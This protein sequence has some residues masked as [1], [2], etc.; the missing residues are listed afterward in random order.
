[1]HF[2]KTQRFFNELLFLFQQLILLE[3]KLQA[4]SVLKVPTFLICWCGLNVEL[5]GFL[6]V[7]SPQIE[8]SGRVKISNISLKFCKLS[9]V[10]KPILSNLVDNLFHFFLP[11]FFGFLSHGFQSLFDFTAVSEADSNFQGLI[12]CPNR[13]AQFECLVV[14]GRSQ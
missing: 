5:V 9:F 4:H 1:M 14:L 3:R 11:P 13:K 7:T 6:V 12:E 2:A 8:N 10:L